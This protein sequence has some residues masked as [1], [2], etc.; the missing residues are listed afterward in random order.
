MTLGMCVLLFYCV[1]S[2]PAWLD[3]V[4]F[5][6]GGRIFV[7]AALPTQALVPSYCLL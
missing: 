7:C 6:A 3:L 2:D 4:G 1:C 5:A